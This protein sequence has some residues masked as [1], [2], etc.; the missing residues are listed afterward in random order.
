MPEE[1]ARRIAA[2]MFAD[3]MGYTALM[4]SDEVLA[5]SNRDKFKEKLEEELNKHGGTLIKMSGDGALCSFNSALECIRAAVAVQLH[6]QEQPKVQLRI[7]IHQAD[8]IFEGGDVHGD[9][10][11]IASRLESFALPGSILIS[12]KV[13]DDIK[14]QKEIQ[15]VSLG[16]YLL[17]NVAEPIEILA[18][19]NPGLQV[20]LNIKLEGKGEK[21]KEHTSSKKKLLNVGKWVLPVFVIGMVALIFIPP[22]MKKQ[23]ARNE[24]IPAIE[25]MVNE[26]FRPPT[27]AY[28]MALEAE[29]YLPDD[30]VLLALWPKVATTLNINSNPPGAEVWW[31]DYDKPESE[32]RMLGITPLENVRVPRIYLR[33]EVRKSGYQT[34]EYAG[35][36]A[37]Q[38][39]AKYLSNIRLDALDALPE[40]MVR[41]PYDTVH[42]YLVGL[43][44]N[45]EAKVGEFLMD[46]YEVTNRQYKA[47]MDAGGYTDV[48]F[49]KYPIQKNG[50]I[51]S[52]EEM[53][54]IF[55]DKT[56]RTGPSTWEAGT[57]HDG[58]GDHPVTGVSWY[59][60]AA[61][62]AF[63][64]KQLPTI[65]HWVSAA[66]TSRTEYIIP[67]SNFSG[68]GTIAVGTLPGYQTLGVY[69][70]AGNAREWCWNYDP[71]VNNHFILGGAFN[72]PTYS[73]NDGYTQHPLD[74]SM[75]NGFR[76]IMTLEQ[77]STLSFIQQPVFAAYRDYRNEKPV[78]DKTFEIIL[79]QYAY[80]KTKLN[81]SVEFKVERDG[82]TIEKITFNAAYNNERMQAYLFLPKNSKPPYQTVIFFPGSGDIYSR[83]FDMEIINGRIDF[84]LKSGRAIVWPVYKGT[85]ERFDAL[86]SDL[87]NETV[88]FKEHMIM[89]RQDIG[90]TLDYLETRSDIQNDKIGFFGWSWGG[91][92]G[93]IMPAVEKRIQCVVL[94]VGGMVMT[95]ALPEADQINFLPRITQPV[96]MLNGK[97]DMFFPLETSQK[98]MYEFL[99]TSPDKK[100]MIVYDAGHLVPRVD[101]VKQTLLWYDTYLG[102]VK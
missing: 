49:W 24:L 63:A 45:A 95:H 86:N 40:G 46:K 20:P 60:A 97:H 12:A 43:E 7:G 69:D 54:K 47:F 100:K 1:K 102:E 13:Y 6:M 80:D 18:I 3:I 79:R 88:F 14:N 31:K 4:E 92:I 87:P 53:Q 93:G 17:K 29:K 83:K 61:Y 85:H 34:I 73:F 51:I 74:R 26:N 67:F 56:G 55:I 44:Q 37:Y 99:G 57:F 98:P 19:S 22:W 25:K 70:L 23:H 35:P 84:I 59:E 32:W 39:L 90:R 27:A 72:D 28:D 41:I 77:D 66:S 9:G 11:N 15:T 78:D 101:L 2:I 42:L 5:L 75:G 81:D 71:N 52:S 33:F 68:S 10:V 58:E 64:K 62:A 30:S 50:K 91:Y 65:Y 82:W 76:C 36:G 16:K 89:W 21:Y 96:L 48:S 38:K 8:V 94:N